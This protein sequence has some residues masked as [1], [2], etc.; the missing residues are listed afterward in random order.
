MKAI[1]FAFSKYG[2]ELSHKIEKELSKEPVTLIKAVKGI[3]VDDIVISENLVSL[4]KRDTKE[5]LKEEIKDTSV[6]IFIGACGIAVRLMAPF[7]ISKKIDPAVLVLDDEGNFCISLVSGHLGG[8]NEWT[9]KIAAMVDAIPVI[10]TSTD[11]HEVFAVDVFA[12]KNHLYI[13]DMTL[14]KEISATLLQGNS[15][16]IYSD[17]SIKDEIDKKLT[18]VGDKEC[19]KQGEVK[20]ENKFSPSAPEISPMQAREITGLK[21]GIVIGRDKKSIF[22]KSLYLYPKSFV[23]GIGCRKGTSEVQIEEGI[24]T[25]LKNKNISIQEIGKLGSIDLKKEEEGILSFSKKYEIPFSVFSK[26]E[27]E[28][29]DGDFIE[30][31]FVSGVTGVGNVCERSASLLGNGK[32]IH[33]KEIVNGITLSVGEMDCEIWFERND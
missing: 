1:M 14:A 32:I 29:A 3:W 7:L 21:Y 28:Q 25:F 17:I 15:V 10:T 13:E 8:A 18:I 5:F 22:P 9:N 20:S 26:E 23:L 27:L 31:S 33:K 2:Y 30:S 19:Q 16:G 24:F 4:N 11:I 6:I 12:K